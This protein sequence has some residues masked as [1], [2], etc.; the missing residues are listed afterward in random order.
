MTCLE[1]RDQLPEYALGVLSPERVRDLERHL[2][3]CAGCRRE[4][5][6]LHQ[7]VE[8]MS[9]SLP[10]A[11]PPPALG[12]R[13]VRGVF[14]GARS[15][16]SRPSAPRRAIRVLAAATLAAA[17]VAFGA[18][19]WGVAE[20]HRAESIHAIEIRQIQNI[21]KLDTLIKSLG[22]KPFQAQLIPVAGIESS[23]TAVIV[24]ASGANSV[25]IVDVLPL[26]QNRGPYIVQLIDRSGRV[27]SLGHLQNSTSGDLVFVQF[28]AQ[29]LSRVLSVTILDAHSNVVMSG[30][31]APYSR[32]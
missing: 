28:T 23:G 1:A 17:L 10:Q 4:T 18:I 24:S 6:E 9:F 26:G 7:G 22:G 19:G 31:V 8:T 11:S 2:E 29:D 27:F 14:Q 5:A 25:V 3:G 12:D 20:R 15:K 30:K 21:D 16:P 13:V 32:G